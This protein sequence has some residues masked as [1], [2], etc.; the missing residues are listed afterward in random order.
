MCSSQ[1]AHSSD[2]NPIIYKGVG[3]ICEIIA[4]L[5]FTQD[6]LIT[7]AGRHPSCAA[8]CLV[9]KAEVEII[10]VCAYVCVCNR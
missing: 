8:V 10:A 5:R 6:E 1:A 4:E 7:R 9:I 2:A 3:V